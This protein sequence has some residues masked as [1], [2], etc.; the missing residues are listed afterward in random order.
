[1]IGFNKLGNH[2][3]LG[4]QMFQYAALKGIAEK[5]EYEWC[6]PNKDSFG[7][8]YNL[9]SSIYDCFKLSSVE[10][11]EVIDSLTIEE[12]HFHF[13]ENLFENCP[14]NINLMGYF[15]TE[16]YFKHIKNEILSDF[17][18]LDQIQDT[19]NDFLNQYE[20]VK[21][22]SVHVRRTDYVEKSHFHPLPS[23][24]YYFTAM[25][26]FNDAVFFVFSDD[27]EW[28]KEQNIFNNENIIFPSVNDRYIDF[29]IMSMCDHNIIA[30]SSYSWW[31]S[32]LNKN[33]N[34]KI[35]APS[36]WFGFHCNLEDL[37]MD[38]WTVIHS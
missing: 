38:N 15:Q 7:T 30:N 36:V 28:C 26:L 11:V 6:I 27:I 13:D 5:H 29:C 23:L 32:Y 25:N 22:V 18:F 21:K 20:N 8:T 37:Y 12:S 2:G 17:E 14:D 9:R 19:S 33:L 31:A 1:M 3:H 35:I 34:K 4:N 24:N 10:N 16:K